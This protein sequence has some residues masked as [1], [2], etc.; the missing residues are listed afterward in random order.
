MVQ[1]RTRHIVVFH[2]MKLFVL[3][4]SGIC[5]SCRKSQARVCSRAR[6]GVREVCKILLHSGVTVAEID[7]PFDST[8]GTID[9]RHSYG[10]DTSDRTNAAHVRGTCQ[11]F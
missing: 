4:F 1:L 5:H 6:V 7:V 9:D 8:G 3:S 2:F 11:V 10:A